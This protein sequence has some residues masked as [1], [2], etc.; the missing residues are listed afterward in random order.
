MA[1][2]RQDAGGA[3]GELPR[4]QRPSPLSRGGSLGFSSGGGSPSPG[5]FSPGGGS[6]GG[7]PS[8]GASGL[9]AAS[10]STSSPGS[11]RVSGARLGVVRGRMCANHS[12]ASLS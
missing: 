4:A 12:S 10:G 8:L 9:A 2:D 6:S 1:Y 7:S 5:F 3:R 11:T